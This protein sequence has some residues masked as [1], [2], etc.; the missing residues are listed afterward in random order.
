[1]R[2]RT[3]YMD[4]ET[5]R[6]LEDVEMENLFKG[7]KYNLSAFICSCIKQAAMNRGKV[8]QEMKRA[9]FLKAMEEFERTLP[10]G[11][12]ILWNVIDEKETKTK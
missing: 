3:F 10:P 12:K 9:K 2:Q 5:A 11:K 1:M 4:E 7:N 6:I 8:L